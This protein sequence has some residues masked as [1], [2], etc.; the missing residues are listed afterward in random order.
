MD[1]K[2][3]DSEL[4]K[5]TLGVGDEAGPPNTKVGIG[6]RPACFRSTFVEILYVLTCTMAVAMPGFLQ[7]SV[8]VTTNYIAE[9][10]HMNQAKITWVVAAANLTTGSFLLFFGR[11]TDLFGRKIVIIASLF[12]FAVVCLGAGFSQDGL[13]LDVI[14]GVRCGIYNKL[15][16]MT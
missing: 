10:L 13:T 3:Y 9:D 6:A 5:T 1:E 12:F 2:E 11:L 15:L 8:Q 14:N 4:G 16:S 7:G